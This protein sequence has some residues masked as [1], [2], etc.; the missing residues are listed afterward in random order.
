MK[1]VTGKYLPFETY[2]TSC[3]VHLLITTKKKILLFVANKSTNR[4]QNDDK[5]KVNVGFHCCFVM[6]H[7]GKRG[8]EWARKNNKNSIT[9]KNNLKKKEKKKRELLKINTM[10]EHIRYKLRSTISTKTRKCKRFQFSICYS[11]YLWMGKHW[12][13]GTENNN[14]IEISKYSKFELLMFE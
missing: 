14:Q 12:P 5:F 1:C 6:K 3:W 10:W 11:C 13:D 8:G 4:F 9:W 7:T 2:Q